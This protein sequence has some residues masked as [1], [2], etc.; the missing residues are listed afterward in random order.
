LSFDSLRRFAKREEAVDSRVSEKNS[1]EKTMMKFK[2]IFLFIFLLGIILP[3]VPAAEKWADRDAEYRISFTLPKK[4]VPGF[5]KVDNYALPFDLKNGFTVWD[6]AGK[7]YHF[8]FNFRSRE[9]I[10]AAPETDNKKVYVYPSRMALAR[11]MDNRRYYFHDRFIRDW[12]WWN[13]QSASQAVN[14]V[15]LSYEPDQ[16]AIKRAEIAKAKAEARAKAVAVKQ[17]AIKAKAAAK[18]KKRAAARARAIAKSKAMNKALAETLLVHF[19]L[20]RNQYH[21]HF[22]L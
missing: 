8:F 2:K 1:K 17:A 6:E 20:R 9:L 5:W 4:G 21:Q 22:L 12:N 7:K 16:A 10:L 14:I 19:D 15:L 18:A 13:D 11:I 3:A